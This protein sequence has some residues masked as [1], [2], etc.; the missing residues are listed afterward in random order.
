MYTLLQYLAGGWQH[1]VVAGAHD[2]AVRLGDCRLSVHV[3]GLG[4][5]RRGGQGQEG[6]ASTRAK[7][8]QRQLGTRQR[9]GHLEGN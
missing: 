3:G 1:H 6:L 8:R 2:A 7:V 5:R 4:L 9:D